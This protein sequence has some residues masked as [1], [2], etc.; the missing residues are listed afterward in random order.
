MP[1]GRWV[2]KVWRATLVQRVPVGPPAPPEPVVEGSS[3]VLVGQDGWLYLMG[4]FY[5]ECYPV[6]PPTEVIQG[7]QR[8]Q[9]ILAATG[10]KL[11]LPLA[12]DKSPAEP[13]GIRHEKA[14][15]GA[16]RSGLVG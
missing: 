1:K 15:A 3:T 16:A 5:K 12:P 10:R 11:V 6:T 2:P 13:D 14:A 4:E 7:L 8:L 9:S